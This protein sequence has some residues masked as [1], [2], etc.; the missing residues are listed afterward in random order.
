MRS[1][2]YSLSSRLTETVSA[3]G[4]KVRMDDGRLVAHR[5]RMYAEDVER[6]TVITTD[7]CR[8]RV[9]VNGRSKL[10]FGW[11]LGVRRDRVTGGRSNFSLGLGRAGNRL[12]SPGYG[13]LR[14]G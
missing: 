8:H 6:R 2:E 7:N 3:C 13:L 14:C 10:A 1:I 11:G 4:W 9:K 5:H 12:G